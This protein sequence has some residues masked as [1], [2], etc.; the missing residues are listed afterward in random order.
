MRVLIIA[1]V[2]LGARVASAQVQDLGHR[3]P[4]GQGLDAGTQ[5]EQGIYLGY[6]LAWFG[7]DT[8][9]D[10]NGDELPVTGF[11]LDA[12]ANV[13]G[14]AG[15][16]QLGEVYLGAA[17]AVPVLNLSLS[18]DVPEADI[19]RLGLGDVYIEPFKIGTRFSHADAVASYSFY[20]PTEQA[21][22]M[23]VGRPQ[24]SHQLM[25]GGTAFFDDR[26]GWRLSAIAS[27]LIN[28]RKKGIDI[29]RGDSF[30]IQGGIGGPVV[31][32]DNVGVDVGV[33]GYA[34]WQV[35]D[36]TG[37]DLPPVLSGARERAFGLGPE[38]DV[39]VRALRSRFL[40]RLVFDIDGKARPVGR[41]LVIGVSVVAWR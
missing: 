5:P 4:G 27:F 21:D 20:I 11:D 30:L 40:A 13:F 33:A 34:M 25:A 28:Q 12:V 37:A 18:A 36:D 9:H 38:V 29:T 16:A 15:T 23:G 35:T 19:D 2:L 14:I 6:R 1:M 8:I 3:L 41:M 31:T 24:W 39:T 26:R 22:R 32:G 10:R 7:S 17:V